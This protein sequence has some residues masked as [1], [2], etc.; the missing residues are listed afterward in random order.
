MSSQEHPYLGFAGSPQWSVI[1]RALQELA[2][3]RDLVETTAHEYIVGYLCKALA[4]TQMPGLDDTTDLRSR[5]KKVRSEALRSLRQ[6]I[7]K[8]NPEGR[9]LVQELIAERRLE[10]QRD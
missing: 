4:D 7:K 6:A 9:D 10:G 3:N 1:D 5:S 8:A 2:R